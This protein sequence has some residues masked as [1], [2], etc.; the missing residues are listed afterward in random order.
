MG[1]NMDMGELLIYVVLIGAFIYIIGRL[2]R[3]KKDK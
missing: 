1:L 2:T 3:R